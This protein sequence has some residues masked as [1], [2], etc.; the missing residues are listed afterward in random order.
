MQEG[1]FI[2]KEDQYEEEGGEAK[3]T[4]KEFIQ[5]ETRQEGQGGGVLHAVGETL[6]E[7]GQT[8]KDLLTGQGLPGQTHTFD[9]DESHKEEQKGQS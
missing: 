5:E 9:K 1:G 8:T 7:I 4:E 3:P 6:A 2:T